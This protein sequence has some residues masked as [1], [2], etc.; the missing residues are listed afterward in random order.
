[1]LPFDRKKKLNFNKYD[2]KQEI[3]I[4]TFTTICML[5]NDKNVSNVSVGTYIS[6]MFPGIFLVLYLNKFLRYIFRPI[7]IGSDPHPKWFFFSNHIVQFWSNYRL[8]EV[9]YQE[10]LAIYLAHSLK[11]VF[12][13]LGISYIFFSVFRACDKLGLNS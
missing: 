13:N 1:M 6:D 7:F 9:Q 3:T 2:S 11:K 12:S 10:I 8:R 5:S 4:L